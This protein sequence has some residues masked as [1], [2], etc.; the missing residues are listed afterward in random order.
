MRKFVLAIA[1]AGGIGHVPVAPGSFGAA[2]GVLAWAGLASAGPRIELAGWLLALVLAVWASSRAQQWLG[3]DDGRI[4]IDEVAG[5]LTGLLLLPLRLDVALAGFA[6]F[7]LF[8]IWK[9]PPVGLLESLPGGAGVTGDDLAAGLLANL[10]G[11]LLWR[12]A[13][14]QGAW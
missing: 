11:Q 1:T 13:L 14:P 8:D 4:V 10:A 12:V 5:Q 7:R 3:P 9:P 2:L 6:L